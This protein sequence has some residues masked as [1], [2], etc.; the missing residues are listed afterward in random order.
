MASVPAQHH[1]HRITIEVFA[2][3]AIRHSATPAPDRAHEKS[4]SIKNAACCNNLAVES[5][6]E[7]TLERRYCSERMN[8]ELEPLYEFPL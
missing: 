5:D 2:S 1:R 6:F 8:L 7:R 4:L 3:A